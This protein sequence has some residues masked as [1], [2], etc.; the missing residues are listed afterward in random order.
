M[1][2]PKKPDWFELRDNDKNEP[3]PQGKRFNR[4]VLLAIPLLVIGIGAFAANLGEEEPADAEG[5][6]ASAP[7]VTAAPSTPT[8]EAPAIA[9]PPQAPRGD[10]EAEHQSF[11]KKRP[12]R[13]EGGEHEGGE[14]HEFG[15]DDD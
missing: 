7:A 1:T 5:I 10:D 15:G 13:N 12:H 3:A 6:V 8:P 14:D 4:G 2:P 9:T 11:G